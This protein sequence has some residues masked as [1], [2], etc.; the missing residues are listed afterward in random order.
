MPVGFVSHARTTV[1]FGAGVMGQLGTEAKQLGFRRSLLVADGGMVSAGYAQRA[2]QALSAAGIDA[3]LFSDFSEN[4]DSEEVE[5][6]RAVAAEFAPD[7]IVALGGG[8]S[9]DCGKAV[10]FVLTNGGRIH[11]YWGYDKAARPLLGMIGIPT[12]TG[13]GSEAQTYAL[14]SEATT[15]RKM[16]IGAPSA[17]FRV[18]LLDPELAMSQPQGV[19]RATGYDALSHA[20]E[21]AATSRR[22]LASLACSREAWRLLAG[23]FE[24]LLAGTGGVEEMAEMQYGAFLAGCAIEHSMLGAAH[25][26]ANPLTARYG[27]THGVA[28]ALMLAPVVRINGS[29]HYRALDGFHPQ[30]LEELAV[31]A[32][33]PRRLRDVGVAREELEELAQAAAEQWTGRFNPRPFD[34]ALALEMYQCAY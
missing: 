1:V 26:T 13:T 14:I 30:R 6:G 32:N 9:L 3:H 19:L 10:N 33:L 17:A 11:D 29:E 22:N 4:P 5:R 12:T 23:N 15:H 8:S 2:F 31:A 34:A 18:V 27:I 25:A 16:A 20:V 24:R 7:S 21:T 28:I